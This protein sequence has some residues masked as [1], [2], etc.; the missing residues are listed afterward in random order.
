MFDARLVLEVNAKKIVQKGTNKESRRKPKSDIYKIFNKL[1]IK[2]QN[3]II[4]QK[5]QTNF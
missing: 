5:F 1:E 2:V 4:Q 3:H